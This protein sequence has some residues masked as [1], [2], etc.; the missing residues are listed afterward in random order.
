MEETDLDLARK[1]QMEAWRKSRSKERTT[2]ENGGPERR[3]AGNWKEAKT[4]RLTRN[5]IRWTDTASV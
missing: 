2:T 3:S 1:T 5:A 4:Q